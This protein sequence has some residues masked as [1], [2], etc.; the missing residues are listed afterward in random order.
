MTTAVEKR[1][2]LILAAAQALFQSA[3]VLVM[4]LSGLV[5]LALSPDKALATLPIAASILG[6]A[7]ATVPASLLMKRIGRRPGFLVG[8][9]TGGLGGALAAAGIATSDF[10]LFCLGN[11]LVGVYQAFA[12]YYR[13]AA[14]DSA[15]PAFR[16]RA[17]SLVLAGGVVAAVAGP[18][19]AKHT[20]DLA[21]TTYLGSYLAMIALAALAAAL[22]AFVR[23]PAPGADER[24][25][26]GRPLIDIV[27]QPVFITAL[28]GSV[29]GY[30]VMIL[31]MTA[32][33][34]AMVAHHHP[35]ADAAFVIQWHVLGMFV[36]SFFTGSLIARFGVLPVMGTGIALLAGHVG[37]A[38]TGV[39]L[40]HFLSGLVLLGV[41]WNFLYVGGTTLLTEAYRPAE[42][43]K[44]QAL[45]EFVI[46]GVVATASFASGGIL[47]HLDWRWVNLGALPLLGIGAATLL[48]LAAQRKRAAQPAE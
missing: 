13:F 45:N 5:G 14:A 48:W 33:P 12:Q 28:L 2:V 39:A 3:T 44:T 32:T 41:G 15:S 26:Q 21:A 20:K 24:R 18:E 4:T 23:I 36:P 16:S 22:L 27:R 1:N 35:V 40:L 19:I 10:A 46:F 7:A 43:A 17:I 8:T 29:A 9:A 6:T 47:H 11:V 25:E 30:A 38:L 34:L 42:R 37:I 31:V